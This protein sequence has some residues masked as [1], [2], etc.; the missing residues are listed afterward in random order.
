M[1]KW[2][3]IL[4]QLTK[5]GMVMQKN[6]PYRVFALHLAIKSLTTLLVVLIYNDAAMQLNR[7]SRADMPI[8]DPFFS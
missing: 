5:V 3:N 8:L 1:N 6:T 4:K 2:K 7:V